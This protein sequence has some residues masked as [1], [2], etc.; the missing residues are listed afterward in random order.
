MSGAAVHTLVLVLLSRQEFNSSF[1]MQGK[2]DDDGHKMIIFLKTVKTTKW[3]PVE[4]VKSSLTGRKSEGQYSSL[5]LDSHKA[6]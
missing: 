3:T 1:E 4:M 5:N 6:V 2:E